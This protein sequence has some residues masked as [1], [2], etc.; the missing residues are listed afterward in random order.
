M[1]EYD[2]IFFGLNQEPYAPNTY[3]LLNPHCVVVCADYGWP[4]RAD[5]KL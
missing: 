5:D 2:P 4:N 1:H 3:F